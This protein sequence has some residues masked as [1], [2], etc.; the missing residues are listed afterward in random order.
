M[1]G[2]EGPRFDRT[3][4]WHFSP[5]SRHLA[6]EAEEGGKTFVVLDHTP[7]PPV[8]DLRLPASMWPFPGAF[9]FSPDSDHVAAVTIVG[10]QMRPLVDRRLGPRFERLAQP[11]FQGDGTVSFFGFRQNAIFRIRATLD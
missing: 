6:Y 9:D 3:A 8:D 4:L 5:D 1:D 2:I 11:V 7:G 10:A